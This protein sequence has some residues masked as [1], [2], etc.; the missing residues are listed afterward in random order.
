MSDFQKECADE[1]VEKA[2][3][4][5]ENLLVLTGISYCLQNDTATKRQIESLKSI[6]AD[7]ARIEY[8]VTEYLVDEEPAKTEEPPATE[9]SLES[10]DWV[11]ERHIH[12]VL[13]SLNGNKSQA[14]RVLGIERST[15]DRKLKSYALASQQS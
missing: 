15:L 13:K 12:S 6:T 2:G 8:I 1:V 7:V 14:A 3:T 11:V 4:I 5:R 10:I 9:V